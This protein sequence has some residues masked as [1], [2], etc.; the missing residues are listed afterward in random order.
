MNFCWK[1]PVVVLGMHRSGTSAVAGCLERLGI[2][3]GRRLAPGDEWNPGGYF[4]DR[5]LVELNDRLL[6]AQ[7]IRWDSLED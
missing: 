4:E 5:D 7:G 2:C 1:R 3:M 6:S